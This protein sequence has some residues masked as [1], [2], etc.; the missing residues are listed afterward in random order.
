[1]VWLLLLPSILL[2]SLVWLYH[3]PSTGKLVPR[4]Q[5]AATYQEALDR[6]QALAADEAKAGPLLD[7]CRSRLMTHGRQTEHAIVLLHGYTNCPEQFAQL[8]DC[9]YQLGH[10]VLIP[11]MPYHGYVDRLTPDVDKLTAEKLVAYGDAAVDLARGLGRRVTVMGLSGSGTVTAWLA[12]TRSD[13]DYALPTAALIGVHVVPAFLTRPLANVLL[14]LPSL[15]IW[16]DPRTKADNPDSYA[17]AYPRYGSHSLAQFLR[18]GVAVQ[19]RA[20]RA[21]PACGEIVMVVNESEPSVNNRLVERLTKAWRKRAFSRVQ[22][23]RF[24]KAL[25]LPHDLISP[26]SPGVPTEW[27]YERMVE[28]VQRLHRAPPVVG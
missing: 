6:Y 9:F 18:L 10:N 3:A 11:R 25:H 26:G 15:L 27:V 20:R 28:Q 4:P 12:Q 22:S 8:G 7:V 23:Y 21:A 19:Q 16:W 24:E 5:P 14:A 1:M 2:V 13:V 17:H